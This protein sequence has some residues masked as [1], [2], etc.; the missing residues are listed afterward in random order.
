MSGYVIFEAGSRLAEHGKVTNEAILDMLDSSFDLVVQERPVSRFANQYLDAT[1]IWFGRFQQHALAMRSEHRHL[2][3]D[4][5]LNALFPEKW[6]PN[7][8][9]FPSRDAAVIKVLRGIYNP[10][11]VAKF[12]GEKDD[13]WQ[14][15][16][17]REA[18]RRL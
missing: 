16:A 14:A 13:A 12:G 15:L 2:T 5:V 3:R 8:K 10:R 11:E 1:L 7:R 4:Q 9:G 6:P 18:W 17:V